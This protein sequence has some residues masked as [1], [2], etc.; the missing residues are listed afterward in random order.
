MSTDRIRCRCGDGSCMLCDDDGTIPAPDWRV[1]RITDHGPSAF[2]RYSVEGENLN[3]T[4]GSIDRRFS[5]SIP[6]SEIENPRF[7]LT[8]AERVTK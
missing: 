8:N 5:W 4:E 6:A 2:Y 7:D 3:Y 1:T